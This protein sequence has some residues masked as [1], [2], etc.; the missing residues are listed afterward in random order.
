MRYIV[1]SLLIIAL[2]VHF[3]MQILAQ[4]LP[5]GWEYVATPNTH[6]ISIPLS[7][8]PNING[9]SLMPGDWIGVFYL[10]NNGNYACGGA[11]EWGG[12]QNTGIIAFGNDS[13]TPVKDGFAS[14]E[15]ITYRVY[16]WSVQKEYVDVVVT[17]NNEL[18][19]SCLNFTASALSGL[20][21]LEATGFY[22]VVT[23]S[24]PQICLGGSVQLDAV[25]SG[26]SGN[27]TYSWSSSPSG[28]SSNVANPT[29]QPTVS[30]TYFAQV[31]DGGQS[32]TASVFVEVVDPPTAF[33]G[34]D[35][36]ACSGST[37][38]LIGAAEGAISVNWSTNGD[39]VFTDPSSLNTAY[40]PGQNDVSA[41]VVEVCLNVQGGAACPVV[42]DCLVLTIWPL[43]DVAL[44]V[45]PDFCLGDDTFTLTGGSPD[46]GIYFINGVEATVF[47]PDETG[48]F[49][50]TYFYTDAN[51]CVNSDTTQLIV[52]DLPELICPGEITV[53]CDDDPLELDGLAVP[54]GGT[55]E[56]ANVVGGFFYPDCSATG[57]YPVSYTYVDTETGCE[58]TCVFEIIVVELPEVSCPDDLDICINAQPIE[59][60][61]ADPPGGNY[62]GNG[63]SNNSFNPATAGLGVHMITYDYVDSNGCNNSCQFFIEVKPLPSVN[64][65]FPVMFI[66]L[67]ETTVHLNDATAM[68]YDDILWSTDGTGVFNDPSLVNPEY[69]LSESDIDFGSVILTMTGIN[70]CGASSDDIAIIV[71]ECQPALVDAGTDTIICET[72]VLQISD[73]QAQF[74]ESLIW[75]NNGGDGVFSDSTTLNPAYTPGTYDIEIGKVTLTLTAF[76]LEPCDTISDSRL[77][78]ITIAPH[79]DAG[80]NSTI[81]ENHSLSLAAQGSNY[82]SLLW[83][84]SGDGIFSN[85]THPETTYQPGLE[86]IAAGELMLT[87][88]AF[89]LSPCAVTYIDNIILGVTSLPV[90]DAGEDV[91]ITSN[92]T[93]QLNA[94]A[95]HY[96]LVLWST[97]GDGVFSDYE[98]LNPVYTPGEED[99]Q[100]AEA[101]LTLTAIPNSPCELLVEDDL[102]VTIDTLTNISRSHSNATF[103]LYPNPAVNKVVIQINDEKLPGNYLIV[104]FFDLSGKLVLK[105]VI[106]NQS[107]LPH[108]SKQIN[109]DGMEKGL[110][111]IR[112]GNEFFHLYQKLIITKF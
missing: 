77:L 55:Y 48:E 9:Y 38:Q 64:A 86:D 97:S 8:D 75:S 54:A 82:S 42:T 80:D 20:A 106:N 100:N 99:I 1:T 18:P 78:L 23:S 7:S 37:F 52:N 96:Q 107:F 33:A 21:S 108:Y 112:I 57:S 29:A 11:V 17:C 39:G 61:G 60:S 24:E 67:P 43:P 83:S 95:A 14:G 40:I 36:S 56:G 103:L 16:S 81:C 104:E 94:D 5:P 12:V 31:F 110:Y 66:V 71:K 34:A 15:E 47:S 13:F 51:G 63:V 26:G 70:D 19:N 102:H 90:V 84:T 22:L 30:T 4:G 68:N 89:P 50:L 105:E 65:G 35:Q 73:A 58:N 44:P 72:D 53:C 28:F 62:S 3:S 32:L 98:I 46:G 76:P 69:T 91:T 27:H 79:I 87:L 111:L 25:P 6:I 101:T 45:Y 92:E 85:P 10:D 41:G 93:L 74:F 2:N 49:E 109:L 59:L 88:E